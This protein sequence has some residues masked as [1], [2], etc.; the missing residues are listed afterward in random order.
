MIRL[1]SCRLFG[2]ELLVPLA[3]ALAL[4]GQSGC[5][6]M[7]N[8]EKGTLA[9]GGLGAGAGAIIGSVTHHPLAGTAIGGALGAVAGGLTGHAIDESERK[10]DAKLAAATAPPPSGPMTVADVAQMARDHIS[11]EVIINQIRTTGTIFQL[12]M[13]DITY[14]KENGV[15]DMVIAAMQ[16]TVYRYPRR[17]YTPVPVYQPAPV[18]VVEPAPPPPPI[19]VG[20]GFSYSRGH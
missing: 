6:S 17:V 7:N 18:V 9:G 20:V 15:S 1:G 13:A 12:T 11:D 5:A 8:T 16:N 19:G 4:V 3:A 14:L 10:Q 2:R